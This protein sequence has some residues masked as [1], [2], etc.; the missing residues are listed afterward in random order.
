M[1][2]EYLTTTV[3]ELKRNGTTPLYV[4]LR[5]FPLSLKERIDGIITCNLAGEGE[6][7]QGEVPECLDNLAADGLY[8]IHGLWEKGTFYLHQSEY[9]HEIMLSEKKNSKMM[10]SDNHEQLKNLKEI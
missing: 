8:K 1:A 6:I 4:Q 3:R 7:I 9:L 2:I 5:A 10:Y